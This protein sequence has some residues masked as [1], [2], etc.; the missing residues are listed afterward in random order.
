MCPLSGRMAPVYRDRA[1]G[2]LRQSASRTAAAI[3][4][5]GTLRSEKLKAAE[6]LSSTAQ[7]EAITDGA[8]CS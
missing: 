4:D 7:A 3:L 6:E 1:Q 8:N 2:V 5:Y